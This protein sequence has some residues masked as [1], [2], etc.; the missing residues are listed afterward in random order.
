MN[1]NWLDIF[2]GVGVMMASFA[3]EPG[4]AIA[5]ILLVLLGFLLIYLGRKGVLEPLLMIP[6]GLGMATINVSAMFFDPI[7]MAAGG[8]V[9][10]NAVN[11]LFLD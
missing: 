4:I 10:P 1:T 3:N 8:K 9:D 2:Q 6:M 11:N 7:N 5:R